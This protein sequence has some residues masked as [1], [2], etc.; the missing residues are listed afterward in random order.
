MSSMM[1]TQNRSNFNWADDDEDDF[2]FEAWKATADTSAPTSDSLPSLQLP[3]SKIEPAFATT[4]S[5]SNEIAPWAVSKPNYVTAPIAHLETTDWRCAKPLLAW[6]AMQDTPDVPAYPELS[7]W[8]NGV[9]SP[10]YRVQY[11]QHWKNWKVDAGVDCRFPALLRGSRM[12]E[13]EMAEE[14]EFEILPDMVVDLT[15]ELPLHFDNTSRDAR[16]ARST[17]ATD[18]VLDE[19]YY[20]DESRLPLPTESTF[21]KE[22]D[23]HTSITCVGLSTATKFA[24]HSR[25]DSMDALKEITMVYEDTIDDRAGIED[26]QD[27]S[28][29]VRLAEENQLLEAAVIPG[30]TPIDLNSRLFN[31]VMTGWYCLSAGPWTTAAVLTSGIVLGGAMH[32][33]RKR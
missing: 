26:V 31:V 30:I 17:T 9:S 24:K 10:G 5:A 1:T 6:R 33:W 28:S 21:Q 19:G 14:D 18:S 16:D 27:N 32:M 2:D 20:S 23:A 8:D 13:I 25:V 12:K 22:L 7:A 3:A 15:P 29:A 4:F 11:S